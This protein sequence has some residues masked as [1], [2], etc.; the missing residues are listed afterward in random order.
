MRRS[1]TYRGSR[2]RICSAKEVALA[3]SASR[4]TVSRLVAS[5]EPANNTED[6]SLLDAGVIFSG[7][8]AKLGAWYGAATTPAGQS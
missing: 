1:R 3:L 5:G 2:C 8:V 4:R 7:E 6:G